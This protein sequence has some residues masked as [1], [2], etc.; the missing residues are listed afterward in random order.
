MRFVST[1]SGLE[2]SCEGRSILEFMKLLAG[3]LIA[4]FRVMIV[5]S[6]ALDWLMVVLV[7]MG[8]KGIHC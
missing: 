5:L 4:L 6:S 2:W 3:G 7:K 8:L 1:L